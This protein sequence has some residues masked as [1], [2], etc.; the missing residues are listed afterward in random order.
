MSG[1]CLLTRKSKVSRSADTQIESLKVCSH[2]NRKF[3]G[4][5]ARKSKVSTCAHT[6]IE[7]SRSAHTQIDSLNVCSHANRK[8][9][10]LLT[11]Q[12]KGS[13]SAHT[14]IESFEFGSTAN[15]KSQDLLTRKFQTSSLAVPTYPHIRCIVS[16]LFVQRR[17]RRAP[18]QRYFVSDMVCFVETPPGAFLCVHHAVKVL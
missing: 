5:L 8:F 16:S 15:R 9:Q 3:Q 14:Q 7:I 2:A 1:G 10:S 4:L 6:Q 17:V 12:S 18:I 13:R 11:R